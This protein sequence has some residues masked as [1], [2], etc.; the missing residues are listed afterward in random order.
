MKTIYMAVYRRER[1][2]RLV[3]TSAVPS[4]QQNARKLWKLQAK[5][6]AHA[7]QLIAE[8]AEPLYEDGVRFAPDGDGDPNVVSTVNE[9][10]DIMIQWMQ[11]GMPGAT[12][13]AR[14]WIGD[15]FMT[16]QRPTPRRHGVIGGPQPLWV[17]H[18]AGE[19][20]LVNRRTGEPTGH[21]RQVDVL[22]DPKPATLR[23]FE[24]G[25]GQHARLELLREDHERG[26][27]R[28]DIGRPWAAV[29]TV[30]LDDRLG[31]SSYPNR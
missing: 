19:T 12:H 8:G 4:A 7:R 10:T 9:L 24:Q 21:S 22:Y 13:H 20:G 18:W 31:P 5:S 29:R 3:S 30:E 6:A 23:D 14:L 1:R 2:P 15:R 16:P 27:S 26:R 17:W 11:A 28:S 25:R